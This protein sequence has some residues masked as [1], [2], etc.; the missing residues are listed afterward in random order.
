MEKGKGNWA[1]DIPELM[2][3]NKSIDLKPKRIQIRINLSNHSYK[4]HSATAGNQEKNN[5]LQRNKLPNS[6]NR[7]Q[8]S[9]MK[10][11]V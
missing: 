9:R 1:E 2:K 3:N 4:H 8:M 10:M 11:S 5:Y 6:N 7:I